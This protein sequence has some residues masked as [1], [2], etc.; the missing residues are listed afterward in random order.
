MDYTSWALEQVKAL[1]PGATTRAWGVQDLVVAL[2][3]LR[4]PTSDAQIFGLA[5][6]NLTANGWP[7]IEAAVVGGLLEWRAHLDAAG[8]IPALLELDRVGRALDMPG[9]H[10]T[11]RFPLRCDPLGTRVGLPAEWLQ[12]LE[13]LDE[14]IAG[15]RTV[16][17]AAVRVV[18][19]DRVSVT[20][21]KPDEASL[22]DFVIRY[23]TRSGE[24]F[25]REI[26]AFW[27]TA[28]G[29]FVD[30]APLLGSISGWSYGDDSWCIGCGS[31][32][33][34][35][36]TIAVTKKA[37]LLAAK[38][39]DRDDDGVVLANYKNLGAFVDAL[40][41]PLGG[42]KSSQVGPRTHR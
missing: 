9:L 27:A 37:G 8:D 18:G 34:G 24:A 26:A 22:Y 15:R 33:Q 42:R 12:R 3:T 4:R 36:L 7:T 35:T 16:N 25:P 14:A 20:F 19:A 39:V 21:G 6:S 41:H 29:V 17:A 13:N 38:V 30:D 28:D 2:K 10:V 32:F 1:R 40:L 23:E 11:K 31:Y 5:A